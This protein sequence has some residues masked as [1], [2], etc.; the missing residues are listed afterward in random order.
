MLQVKLKFSDKLDR[1]V[2][3]FGFC[4]MKQL[5]V[6]L[7]RLDGMLVYQRVKFTGIHLCTRGEG[8]GGGGRLA[9]CE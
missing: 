8:G 4:S 7:L 9:L 2:L 5:G 6:Y 1:T 3:I